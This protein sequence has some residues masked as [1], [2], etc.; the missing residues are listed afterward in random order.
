MK[1]KKFASIISFCIATIVA[2]LPFNFIIGSKAACFSYSSMS[3]PALGY[4]QSLVYVILYFFTK[5]LFSYSF[6]LLFFLHRL[7]I[8][9]ATIALRYWDFKISVL[10]PLLAILLFCVHPT[11]V[12]VFYYSW[13][14]FIP[15]V[16]YFF[17][18]DTIYCRALIASFVA[19]AVGSVIWLYCG[20]IA[21]E[22]WTAL[23]PLVIVER[24][25]IAAGMIGFI[26]LYNF[27]EDFCSHK[28][29]V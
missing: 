18:K 19:H 28:V 23:M 27:I 6:P 15:M 7:P 17:G 20:F 14:W 10:L 22:V 29:A 2:F 3:I 26:S 8:F 4:Q 5:G 1:T 16:I 25:I 21:P 11:G 12:Q 24:L 9:F 13:Y